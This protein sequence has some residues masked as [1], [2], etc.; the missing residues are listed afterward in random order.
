MQDISFIRKNDKSCMRTMKELDNNNVNHLRVGI[1]GGSFNPPHIGHMYI[2]AK[3]IDSLHLDYLIWLIAPKN[4]FKNIEI[5]KTFDI[6]LSNAK[7][8]VQHQKILVSGLEQ[9]WNTQGVT[10]NVIK[11]FRTFY[12]KHQFFWIMGA[13][14]MCQIH[15][16]E[17]WMDIF[18]MATIVVFDRDGYSNCLRNSTAVK[19]FYRMLEVDAQTCKI[20]RLSSSNTKVLKVIHDSTKYLLHTHQMQEYDWIFVKSEKMYISSTQI[21]AMHTAE[22]STNEYK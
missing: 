2:S 12:P 6:R 18:Q 20:L 14:N 8:F 17:E 21:R 4:T 13:D 3:A 15:L 16:W 19:K 10:A 9:D 7:K 22:M 5:S 1:L 11:Q